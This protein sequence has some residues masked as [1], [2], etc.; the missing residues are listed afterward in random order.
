MSLDDATLDQTRAAEPGS[1]T[2]LTANAGSGKTKVLT[3]RVARLLLSGTDPQHIL[4]LT[5]TKAAASEMQNRLFG[6]LGS[7]ALM[8]DARLAEA[9]RKL[10]ETGLDAPERLAEA[11]RLFA[12]AIE[13]PGGLRIQTIHSF[14]AALLRRFPLEAG[15]SPGFVE[16]DD[17]S[18]A[19][20]REEVVS[21]LAASDAKGAFGAIL[22]HLAGEDIGRLTEE[23]LA[24]RAGFDREVS[25]AEIRRWLA[26]PPGLEMPELIAETFSDA[27]EFMP[28]VI[29][30]LDAGSTRDRDAAARLSAI[31]WGA[32]DEKALALCES[33]FLFGAGAQ[34]AFEAK[35]GS[36][37]TKA[38]RARLGANEARLEALMRRVEAARPRRLALHTLAATLALH[39]FARAFLAAYEARKQAL[40][41][42]DFDDLISR[43]IALLEDRAVS[44]WVLYRLD[45]GI[46]HILVDEAQDTSPAQWRVIARLAEEFT[47]GAGSRPDGVARTLFVVGDPKQ[48]IYSFQ[49]ADAREFARMQ[50][51]FA[52]RFA[53]SGQELVP[54]ELAYSFRSAPAILRTVD[55]AFP[56]WTSGPPEN[57]P[58]A[59]RAYY[60][61][62]PGR[63][64][65][66]PLEPVPET[67]EDPFWADPVD[68]LAPG[69]NRLELARKL[70]RHI[71]SLIGSP[72]PDGKGSSRPLTAGDIM[73]LVQRRG[74]LFHAIIQACKAEGLPVA[75]ADRLR[76]GEELAVRDLSALLSFLATPEDDLSLAAALR[77]PLFGWSEADL[78]RLAAAR[79]HRLLR[80]ELE[81]RRD[82]WPETHAMLRDLRDAADFLR[83][84]DL[85]ERILLRH[86]G[87]RRLLAR[88]GEEAE[89]G[90]DAL[91]SQALTYESVEVPSLTGF[92]SWLQAEDVEL[93]RQLGA[94]QG[95]LRV[96]TVHGAKGLEAP[97][98]ILPDTVRRPPS[99]SGRLVAAEA[100]DAPRLRLFW[101]AGEG[102]RPPVV[103][104]A[105]RDWR[106]AQQEERRRLLYVAMT[107]AEQWLIVCGAAA[108][109]AEADWHD[110][111]EH[112][113]KRAGAVR[114]AFP[115]GQGLRYESGL[116]PDS[117]AQV[118]P[119]KP[120]ARQPVQQDEP[121]PLIPSWALRPAPPA[122]LSA[123]ILRPS[124]LPGQKALPGE[125]ALGDEDD[126]LRRGRQLHLLLEHLP[127]HPRAEWPSLA[128]SLLGE[129]ED[130]VREQQEV[131]RLLA[132]AVRVLDDSTSGPLFSA[133]ALTEVGV[134]APLPL[135]GGGRLHGTIDRLLIRPDRILAVDFKTNRIV[136]QTPQDVPAGLLA[137]MG[138]YHAA[139]TQI[140]PDRPVEV[141]LLWTSL[142]RLMPLPDDLVT[143]AFA[144]A[145]AP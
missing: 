15:V 133:E 102:A 89:E 132:D 122:V 65:L 111:L 108:D 9:L 24:H 121:H 50:R 117:P 31:G 17:R 3:D 91:L 25:E 8:D 88:L 5:Y 56:D 61:D 26:L 13:T 54:R 58:V 35:V 130:A 129:G 80:A 52:D 76:L 62:L 109:R 71:R 92:V 12:R 70:A 33:V 103:E 145:C 93:K 22:S 100:P 7:W 126:P 105:L 77:S 36:F 51:H 1:S 46:D 42:L 20:L 118:A 78:Y 64:D 40:A 10:G 137:Q 90:I 48:S 11:R 29:A 119:A 97:V 85:L 116:W 21:E 32:A 41:R 45:G 107:R 136:P 39:R 143:A 27:A 141:A 47:A 2:W 86:D 110:A 16:L 67:P 75:G 59:H 30:A 135:P 43:T 34:R 95:R 94:A 49:G 101:K 142:P 79:E 19:L 87:R 38:T 139:L 72:L 127:A 96:M 84:Y 73:V 6:T 106:A 138:A 37:P 74:R 123:R 55:L 114:V 113:L 125:P 104:A 83:P 140:Y 115:T 4:C 144:R 60:G 128:L 124:E 98:V 81:A 23:I 120:P 63:V 134:T 14:C 69:D 66:W 53:A 68:M 82:E 18:A 112:A 44:P 99:H 57:A 131:E 28:D